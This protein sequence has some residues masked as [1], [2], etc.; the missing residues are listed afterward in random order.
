MG[1]ARF[2]RVAWAAW[3][4]LAGCTPVE[5]PVEPARQAP[6][7]RCAPADARGLLPVITVLQTRDHEVTVHAGDEGLRFTV[8]LAGGELLGRMLTE[9]EFALGFP[10]LH[11][12]FDSAF[13]EDEGWLDASVHGSRTTPSSTREPGD[14]R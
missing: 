11:Q 1:G 2:P 12:R 7:E 3:L 4:T 14:L 9:R 13:A 8:S 5:R 10:G 6:T